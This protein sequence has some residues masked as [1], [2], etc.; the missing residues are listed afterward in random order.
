VARLVLFLCIM[1]SI[2]VSTLVYYLKMQG[3]PAVRALDEEWYLEERS[4]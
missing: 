4:K 1:V 2:C 3:L